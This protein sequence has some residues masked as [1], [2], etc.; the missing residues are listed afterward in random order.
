MDVKRPA[1]A[2]PAQ[3]AKGALR[4]L[5][6]AKSEPTP[7]N[8]A[9]AYAEESGEPLPPEGALPARARLQIERLATRATD[10]AA[11][12]GELIGALMEGRFDVLQRSLDRAASASSGA[13]HAWAL[14]IDR[15]VRGLE[16]GGRLWTGARKKE[17]LQRVLDGTPL[18]TEPSRGVP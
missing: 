6:M 9:R 11:L 2:V 15:L 18:L 8:Y 1:A 17:S 14:Q 13:G 16:R 12:R 3:L 10:D 7:A 4:R 5:A